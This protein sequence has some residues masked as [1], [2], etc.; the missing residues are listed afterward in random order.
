MLLLFPVSLIAGSACNI[1]A[2]LCKVGLCTRGLDL[3]DFILLSRLGICTFF[4]DHGT[5][6]LHRAVM[7]LPLLK[8]LIV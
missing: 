2:I 1:C 7:Q 4:H 3:R 5:Q 8:S 6:I